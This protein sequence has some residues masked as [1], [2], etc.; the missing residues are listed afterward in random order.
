M[1]TFF[2]LIILK[3]SLPYPLAGKQF[4][5]FSFFTVNKFIILSA[6]GLQCLC[7]LFSEDMA[8]HSLVAPEHFSPLANVLFLQL[9]THNFSVIKT[10]K[11]NQADMII[12]THQLVVIF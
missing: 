3:N 4:S 11:E 12:I 10:R 7:L 9:D 8:V 1:I 6:A 5:I 2:R